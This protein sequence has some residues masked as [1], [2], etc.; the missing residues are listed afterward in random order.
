MNK[1]ILEAEMTNER[2][3]K[4]PRKDPNEKDSMISK[5]NHPL[6]LQFKAPT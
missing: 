4:I 1:I 3:G 5:E 6:L 2:D